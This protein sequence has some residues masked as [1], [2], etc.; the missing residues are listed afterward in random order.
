MKR[1][2]FPL[3][4]VA[5]LR[6]HRDL[7]ARQAL[8]AALG[9]LAQADAKVAAA[10]ARGEELERAISAGRGSGFRPDLQ[11]S[12]LSSY[13]RER[14]AEAEAVRQAETARNEAERRRKAAIEAHRQLKIVV[15][16][17]EKARARH[18]LEVLRAE[19]IEFDE[20]AA[21]RSGRKAPPY[22]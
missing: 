22:D 18:R 3:R 15:T 12:F 8:A 2:H 5:V 7:Q 14:Q 13:R 19:Q 10:R 11:I 16:L 6:A 21:S 4:P 9:L 1:F 20:R 17:E